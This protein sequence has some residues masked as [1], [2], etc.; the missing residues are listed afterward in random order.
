MIETFEIQ[1]AI[2]Q[3][4]QAMHNTGKIYTYGNYVFINEKYEGLHIIDNRA[5]WIW[6][7]GGNTRLELYVR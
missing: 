2:A 3:P 1:R 7:V 5:T 6:N 4:A